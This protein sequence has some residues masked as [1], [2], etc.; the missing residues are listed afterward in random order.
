MPS[1]YTAK[2]AEGITFKQFALSC[3]RAFGA[4]I[5]MRDDP[6][7]TKIPDEIKPDD[8]HLKRKK[9]LLKEWN[10]IENKS[11]KALQKIVDSN[12]EDA[13]KRYNK[14]KSDADELKA[15]YEKMLKEAKDWTPPTADHIG[16]KDF[17]IEQ[18]ESSIKWDCNT[19]YDTPPEKE[20]IDEF[21][22]ER[23][24]DIQRDIVYHEEEY[25]KEVAKAKERT[26]WIVK[27]KQSLPK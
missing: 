17:M 5:M 15:K 24:K 26:D 25:A 8:Y 21:L 14:R 19:S 9:E 23:R 18:I 3:A 7:D 27:L 20:S 22:K 11:Q 6:M 16:L 2:I 13:M 12:F 10:E 1:G 4:L